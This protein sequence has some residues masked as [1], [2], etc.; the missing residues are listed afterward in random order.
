MLTRIGPE[1]RSSL[2]FFECWS[3]PVVPWALGRVDRSRHHAAVTATTPPDSLPSE[4]GGYRVVR[5]LGGSALALTAL[6]HAEGKT[7]VAR[8]FRSSCPPAIIDAELAVHDAIRGAEPALRHHTVSL[9]DL[10]T[11]PDGRLAMLL[12]QVAGPVLD[13]VLAGHHGRLLLGEAVTILAP[14]A[15]ALDAAHAAGI[16]SLGLRTNSVRFSV[17]GG[18][19]VIRVQDAV[20]GPPL[21]VRFRALEPAY[22]ADLAALGRLGAFV[23][24]AVRAPDRASLLA[25]VQAPART[26]PLAHALF[27]LADPLAVNLDALAPPADPP[28]DAVGAGPAEVGFV[29]SP[30][31]VSRHATSTATETAAAPPV[32]SAAIDA[33]RALGLSAGVVDPLQS[34]AEGAAR[35]FERLVARWR[36]RMMGMWQRAPSVADR[37]GRS[38]PRPA[39]RMR[40]VVVGAVG[41]AA[42]IVAFTL[43][44]VTLVAAPG[45]SSDGAPSM[46]TS[47][48]AT[49]TAIDGGLVG[50]AVVAPLDADAAPEIV[51]QPEPDQWQAI[52]DVLVG[53]W[54]ECRETALTEVRPQADCVRRVVHDGSAAERLISTD[55]PRHAVLERWR[56]LRGDAI[57]VERMGGAVLI[58]L[59]AGGTTT[60][61]LLLVRSEAGWR[62]RDV[63]G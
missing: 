7:R 43:V 3:S 25:A 34:A 13:D 17:S 60:A 42:I 5:L 10:V 56:S 1:D 62:C 51:L 23:A 8:V 15:G 38:L 37:D 58:D 45:Q 57:V 53:R 6:V 31:K 19:V 36:E 52:V 54:L 27:D 47:P 41:V 50:D 2:T 63:I 30:V 32:V 33:M 44:A 61:S 18:P 16:T 4:L 14:L 55:D 29:F 48:D 22:L 59:V 9:D 21:P 12:E 24:A 26:R 11:L 46:P 39:L 49:G 40:F 20:S 28:C 35:G